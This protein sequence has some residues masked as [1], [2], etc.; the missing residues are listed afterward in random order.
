[1]NIVEILKQK[2]QNVYEQL[3]Q[4]LKRAF[5]NTKYR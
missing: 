4:N 3:S 5:H 1:M 2:Y